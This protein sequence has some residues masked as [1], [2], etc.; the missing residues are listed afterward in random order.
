MPK[1]NTLTALKRH[2]A[3]AEAFI[4]QA[5]A[6]TEKPDFKG[7][8]NQEAEQLLQL[9]GSLNLLRDTYIRYLFHVCGVQGKRI[10]AMFNLSPARISQICA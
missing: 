4:Q 5:H 6:L 1:L 3:K 2:L 10:A 7:L 9:K 8:S